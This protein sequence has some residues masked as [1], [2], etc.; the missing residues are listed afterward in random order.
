MF[1]ESE[2]SGCLWS[3]FPNFYQSEFALNFSAVQAINS[4]NGVVV[5]GT[6]DSV[7]QPVDSENEEEEDVSNSELRSDSYLIYMNEQLSPL[8]SGLEHE[9]TK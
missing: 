6:N 1:E 5:I 9:I 2:I 4:E 3:S 7:A 8:D